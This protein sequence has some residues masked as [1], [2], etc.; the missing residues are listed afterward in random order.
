CFGKVPVVTEPITAPKT[1]F[2]RAPLEEVNAL[3]EED[4]L[5][6]AA[7][8]PAIDNVK[9]NSKGKMYSRANK[10]MANQLLAEA[11]LRSGKNDLAEQQAKLVINSGAF[12]LT[13][14]RFGVSAA[15]P[16][17]PF[18]DMFLY[19]NQRR[20][21]GNKEV[22]WVME[23][24]NPATVQGGITNSPQQRR[25]WVAAY[26]QINGMKIVDSLGGRG[27]ARLRLNDWVNY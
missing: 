19:G 1:D 27:I 16:G 3:I 12:S 26:Y 17:D 6:A 24:E 10:Y 5:Y 7:N 15:K 14:T 20:G 18:A 25:V 4:L 9:S 11:Y 2:V 23:M 8:L 22:I 21:Q 13:T